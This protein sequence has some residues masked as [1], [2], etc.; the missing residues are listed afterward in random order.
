MPREPL[1]HHCTTEESFST[2][3]S[4]GPLHEKIWDYPVQWCSHGSGN[5]THL[6][7]LHSCTTCSPSVGDS[8]LEM[9]REVMTT[10]LQPEVP[11]PGSGVPSTLRARVAESTGLEG[12]SMARRRYQKGRVFLR[13][14]KERVWIGRYREDVIQED[15][16]VRRVEKAVI[17]GPEVEEDSEHEGK[18]KKT[19][20]TKKLAQRRLD[21]I[22]GR[23]NG[24]EYRPVRI[25]SVAD[26]A[27]KWRTEVLVHRKPST[28]RAAKSHLRVYILPKL[29]KLRLDEI[30]R[31]AQQVFVTQLAP[32]VSRKTVTNVLN[33]LSSML[34]T[35][36]NWGYVC[37]PVKFGALVLPEGPVKSAARF[38]TGDEGRKI[39][40]AAREP[41][42]TMFAIAA[43]TGLRAGELLGLQVDDLDFG[44]GLVHVRR[45]VWNG[46]LQTVKSKASCAPVVMSAPLASILREHLTTWRPNPM[47]LLFMNRVGRPYNANKVVQKG[48]WP[49][50]EKLG[51]ERCGLH[52]FRHTHASLL[53]DVGAPPTVTQAQLRHSDPRITL[54]TYGHVIG[55][56]QRNAVGRVSEILRPDAPKL[57]SSGEWIQ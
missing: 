19:I 57:E 30:G 32:N 48:L 27:T 23:I 41:Y 16:S 46:K 29:G 43:M 51:I 20:V 8:I 17:L 21:L 47:K 22:L 10:F 55:D 12:G 15:G 7:R 36:K 49:V 3:N 52:A 28:I 37:E 26:F 18:Q 50:L 56:A 5:H 31:E 40:A 35:A 38:F 44:R 1:S 33:T 42:R 13:G 24:P 45:S 11:L 39:I 6:R 14:R 34:R 2:R 4:I 25:A 54:E 9:A 53:L